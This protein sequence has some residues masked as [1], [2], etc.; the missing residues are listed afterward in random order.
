ML[1]SYPVFVRVH[2]GYQQGMARH[3]YGTPAVYGQ[4]LTEEARGVT[5][6]HLWPYDFP[7]S[8]RRNGTGVMPL[9]TLWRPELSGVSHNQFALR[10]LEPVKAG[11]ANRWVAQRWLCEPM[12]YQQIW[13]QLQADETRKATVLPSPMPPS[14]PPADPMNPFAP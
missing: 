8:A 1:Y 10:G 2:P 3:P 6:A 5:V 14:P 9:A 12:T 7:L 4:L 11:R 13:E